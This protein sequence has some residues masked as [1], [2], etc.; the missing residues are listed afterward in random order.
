[1]LLMDDASVD[2]GDAREGA[3]ADGVEAFGFVGQDVFG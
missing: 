3:E 1:M 2:R